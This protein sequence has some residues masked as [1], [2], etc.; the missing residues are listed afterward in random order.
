M[1]K[2][3]GEYFECEKDCIQDHNKCETC[4]VRTNKSGNPVYCD[5]G[6]LTHP[7]RNH[8]C[9]EVSGPSG[10]T[11]TYSGNKDFV[12]DYN[13]DDSMWF[14]TEKHEGVSD[15]N[16]YEDEFSYSNKAHHMCMLTFVPLCFLS[17]LFQ[18][19]QGLHD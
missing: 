10:G 17:G 9:K 3:E 16:D 4:S 11:K 18:V 19:R 13:E 5:D 6:Q 8:C 12:R 14:L 15:C 1:E 2:H 7:C